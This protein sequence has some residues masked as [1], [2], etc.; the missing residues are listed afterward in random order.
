M[1]LPKAFKEIPA[2]FLHDQSIYKVRPESVK[3][4]DEYL[5]PTELRTSTQILQAIH[6]IALLHTVEEEEA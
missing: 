6:C 3:S 4:Y 1:L 5:K 2:L